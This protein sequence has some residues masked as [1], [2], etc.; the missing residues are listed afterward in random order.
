VEEDE[1]G[2]DGV[3]GGGLDHG[4]GDIGLGRDTMGDIIVDGMDIGKILIILS[5]ETFR[6]FLNPRLLNLP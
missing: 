6:K 4:V 2:V 3:D 5:M 1:V